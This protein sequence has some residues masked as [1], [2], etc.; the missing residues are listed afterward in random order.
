MKDKIIELSELGV[1][2]IEDLIKLAKE[3]NRD[4]SNKPIFGSTKDDQILKE[5]QTILRL[6]EEIRQSIVSSR[7]IDVDK[8]RSLVVAKLRLLQLV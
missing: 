6:A 8:H 2:Q 4:L 5:V 3:I 7:T 1:E